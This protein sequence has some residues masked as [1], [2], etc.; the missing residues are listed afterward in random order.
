MSW[1]LAP[2]LALLA[3]LGAPLFTIIACITLIAFATNGIDTTSVAIEM[4][5]MAHSMLIAIPLFTFAGYLLSEGGA[6]R[7]LVRVSRALLG[8]VPG[9]LALVALVA[10]AVF[11]AFTGASGVTVIAMGGLLLP[12]L[13]AEKYDDRF[14]FGLLTTSGSLGL[15]FPPSLPIILVAYVTSVSVDQLFVAGVLPGILLLLVLG[16]YAVQTARRTGVPRQYFS[17]HELVRAVRGAAWELPLPFVVLGGIYSGKVTVTEAASLTAVYALVAEVLIYRDIKLRDLKHLFTESMVLV[18]GILI[19]VG[20]ALGLTNY[21][22]DAEVPTR[23]FEWIETWIGHRF[24]F[25]MLLNV[26]LLI[27]GCMM[28]IFSAILVVMPLILPVAQAYEVNPVHLSILFLA[29]LE[30]GYFTPPVG[31]NLF[32]GSFRFGKPVMELARASLPFLGLYLLVLLVLTYLP[33]LSLWLVQAFGV[34]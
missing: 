14:T 28:D 7:R 33:G 32:I 25:L 22:I 8:W 21:L 3:L 19:I 30:I 13:R 9:G 4:Y 12:A 10:C 29:N 17:W 11:T 15:L 31:L 20:A 5:R 34:R 27:V 18:G 1:F 23:L 2:L 6:P 16:T 26:F 24:V